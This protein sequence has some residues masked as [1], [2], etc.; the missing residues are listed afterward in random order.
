[1]AETKFTQDYAITITLDPRIRKFSTNEQHNLMTPYVERILKNT[2][3]NAIADHKG[4][5]PEEIPKPILTLVA[6]MTQSCDIHYHGVISFPMEY[7]LRC[8]IMFVRNQFRKRYT[9]H[10]SKMEPKDYI[11]FILLK[12]I[13]DF[14]KWTEYFSKSIDDFKNRTKLGS[15]V[16][17]D[18]ELYD[19]EDILT[20]HAPWCEP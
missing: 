4:K 6:E 12:P 17:D 13:D 20:Y 3:V 5:K 11:G 8:P 19:A 2:C 14:D 7:N 1:M 16:C 10:P 18:Y 9:G 15:I